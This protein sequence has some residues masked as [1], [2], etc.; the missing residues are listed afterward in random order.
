MGWRGPRSQLR[1]AVDA[2]AEMP[3]RSPSGQVARCCQQWLRQVRRTEPYRKT[4]L[5]RERY[6]RYIDRSELVRVFCLSGGKGRG[7]D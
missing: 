1:G 3:D 7:R 2:G 6:P 4:L 5:A